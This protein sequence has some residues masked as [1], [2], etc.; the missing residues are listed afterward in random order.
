MNAIS[1]RPSTA[2][3]RRLQAT[4]VKMGGMVESAIHDAAAALETRDDELAEAGAAATRPSTCWAQVNEEGRAPDR[5]RAPAPP[6]CAWCCRSSRFPQA[7][8]GSGITPEHRQSA[9]IS[10]PSCRRFGAGMAAAAD[11][12]GGRDDA[13][14]RAGRLYPA[15]RGLAGTCATATEGGPDV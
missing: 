2:I 8:N 4:V 14:G 3:L 13:E 7:S 15:R 9:A 12:G 6:T 10:W 11:V 5:L 1:F